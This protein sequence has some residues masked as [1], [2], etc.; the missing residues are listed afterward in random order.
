MDEFDDQVERLKAAGYQEL[1]I[2]DGPGYRYTKGELVLLFAVQDYARDE[3]GAL[4]EAGVKVTISSRRQAPVSTVT[5]ENLTRVVQ[6]VLN[7][8]L[9]GLEGRTLTPITWQDTWPVGSTIDFSRGQ[10]VLD[11]WVDPSNGY[12]L[13]S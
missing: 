6:A 5:H 10:C 7:D 11:S 4:C 3:D 12:Y 9:S 13:K 2:L 1:E 8:G